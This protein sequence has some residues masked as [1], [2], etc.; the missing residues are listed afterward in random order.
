MR[1]PK[2]KPIQPPSNEQRTTMER[3]FAKP[4]IPLGLVIFDL[5][6]LRISCVSTFT[7]KILTNGCAQSEAL[8][9][10]RFRVHCDMKEVQETQKQGLGVVVLFACTKECGVWYRLC[11]SRSGNVVPTTLHVP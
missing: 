8:L 3:H 11:V 2:R 10:F 7:P 1:A 9:M 5:V 6:G 4:K